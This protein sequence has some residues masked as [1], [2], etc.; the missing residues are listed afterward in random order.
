MMCNA[1][2]SPPRTDPGDQLRRL[3]WLFGFTAN[4]ALGIAADRLV[5]CGGTAVLAETPEISGAEHLLFERAVSPEV[6]R[7]LLDQVNWWHQHTALFGQTLNHNPSQGNKAGGLTTIAE[8][9][10][11]AVAKAVNHL[12][13]M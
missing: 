7:K 12:W 2:R 8:K 13:F 11:G 10:L 4:P 9:S 1:R 3:R 5:S 6:G